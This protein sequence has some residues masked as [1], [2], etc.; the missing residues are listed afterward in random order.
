MLLVKFFIFWKVSQLSLYFKIFQNIPKL[1]SVKTINPDQDWL[2]ESKSSEEPGLSSDGR[3]L[4]PPS[5]QSVPLLNT[6]TTTTTTAM[7]PSNNK[8][9]EG[10]QVIHN[11]LT[12]NSLTLALSIQNH[13]TD[14]ESNG[15]CNPTFFGTPLSA[16]NYSASN[17]RSHIRWDEK[18]SLYTFIIIFI[19]FRWNPF[20]RRSGIFSV[21]HAHCKRNRVV[22]KHGKLNTYR[23][24]E[25][26]EEQ[27]R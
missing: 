3:S 1:F 13:N 22:S 11:C 19:I 20:A 8:S 9:D 12:N 21:I 7:F 14:M 17:S 15:A 4:L 10:L 5:R 23:K 25:E 2:C 24:P 27:H 26:N 18:Y 16:S 6:V